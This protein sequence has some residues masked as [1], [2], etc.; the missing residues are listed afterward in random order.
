MKRSCP[1]CKSNSKDPQI[2]SSVVR[3]GQFYRRSDSKRV[4]RYFCRICERSFSS[5]TSTPCYRQNKRNKNE[6]LRRLLCAG[7]SQRAAAKILN[8]SRTTVV[9]KFLFLSKLAEIRFHRSNQN[10]QPI[11]LIEFDDMESFEHTKC[12]PLSMT[13]AVVSKTR[14]ILGVEVA[15]MPPKGLLTKIARKKYGWRVDERLAARTK[16]LT[17]IRPLIAPGATLKSDQSP[18]YPPLVKAY[19]PESD[20]FVYKGRRGCVVG[21]GELKRGGFDPLF[22]L[23]HTCGMFRAHVNRLFRRTWCTTKKPERLL[24]HMILYADFHNQN[25]TV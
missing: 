2:H 3:S 11:D 9:R 18:H 14:R 4:Q 15:R 17:H 7:V 10:F 6:I 24:A 16:L 22:S 13:V 20:H 25:L 1:Y 19:F 23:N 5:A 12:K 8:I 21:Q